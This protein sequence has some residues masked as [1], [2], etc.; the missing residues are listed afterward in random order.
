MRDLKTNLRGPNLSPPVK[1]FVT[2]SG[3]RIQTPR[4]TQGIDSKY[5]FIQRF[6]NFYTIHPSLE[7]IAVRH[8]LNNALPINT[9]CT[10]VNSPV[11]IISN[12][13]NKNNS[14]ETEPEPITEIINQEWDR[15]PRVRVDGHILN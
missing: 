5:Y 14:I 6:I 12:N 1:T 2:D 10:F 4:S 11:G 13:S 7:P 15:R 9:T 3:N 8:I